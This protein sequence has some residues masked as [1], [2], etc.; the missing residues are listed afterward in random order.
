MSILGRYSQIVSRCYIRMYLYDQY[1][2]TTC[3]HGVDLYGVIVK[4][5]KDERCVARIRLELFAVLKII[6]KMSDSPSLALVFS[7][8][9][10][11]IVN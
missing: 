1:L 6:S 9:T 7:I 2:K 5:V 8:Y 10:F 4:F 11:C 3:Q